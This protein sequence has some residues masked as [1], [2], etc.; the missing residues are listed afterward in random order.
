MKKTTLIL[1]LLLPILLKAQSFSVEEA[2][3]TALKNN[4]DIRLLRNDSMVYALDN[5]YAYAALLPS[6]NGQATQLFNNYDQK[7]K[8]SDGSLRERNG[9]KS[10]NTNASVNLNWTIFDGLKMF[11]TKDKVEAYT[12]YGTLALQSQISTTVSEVINTYYEIVREKEQLQ[13]IEEQMI[14]NEERVKQ[15]ENKLNTGLGAKPE[16]LQAKVDLNAQKA[17]KI[18]QNVRAEQ[19]KQHLNLLMAVAPETNYDVADSIPIDKTLNVSEILSKAENTNPEIILARKE[20]D[21]AQI[22]LKEKKADQYPVV[23]LNAAYNFSRYN[24]LTVINDFT[25]LQNRNIGFNYGISTYIPLFNGFNV[26]RQ[27]KE[28]K[29]DLDYKNIL[30]DFRKDQTKTAVVNA[31]KEYKLQISVLQLEEEN[32]LLAKENVY[33]SSERF[34]LGVTGSLEL[35]ETQK[36]LEDAYNRL[37]AARFATKVAETELLRL[38]GDLVK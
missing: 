16:L 14:L 36:S 33:I 11:A 21:I 30:Y 17:A 15:A 24:N 26:K 8:L 12:Q 28:A 6:V 10:G 3:A 32:I 23:N 13:A 22:T 34:R 35:R 38:K 19:L 2:V 7:Q 18:K 29:L 5:K 37:I 25:P 9:I 31:Y 4:Y 27:I 20:I 1:L